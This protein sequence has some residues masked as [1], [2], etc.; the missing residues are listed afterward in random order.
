[1]NGEVPTM[2]KEVKGQVSPGSIG[3]YSFIKRVS[4]GMKLFMTLNRKFKREL[5]DQS[6]V[7]P[8]TKEAQGYRR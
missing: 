8:L 6:D 2:Y 1:M 7:I 5:L 3:V 4:W